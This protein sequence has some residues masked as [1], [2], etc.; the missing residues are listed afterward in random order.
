MRH[1]LDNWVLLLP[2]LLF[3]R[4][5]PEMQPSLTAVFTYHFAFG[6]VKVIMFFSYNS[7]TN[8]LTGVLF[9]YLDSI[10]HCWLF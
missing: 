3:F 6:D 7:V 9:L 1:C 2:Y 4:N 8:Q 5:G 10:F